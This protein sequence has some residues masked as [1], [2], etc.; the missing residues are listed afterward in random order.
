MVSRNYYNI[1]YIK[2]QKTICAIVKITQIVKS[3]HFN[4]KI[5]ESLYLRT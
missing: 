3:F 1:F 2:M 4:I 5:T